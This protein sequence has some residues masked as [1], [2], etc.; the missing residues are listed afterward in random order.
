MK[1]WALGARTRKWD[2]NESEYWARFCDERNWDART[3]KKHIDQLHTSEL[4][5]DVLRS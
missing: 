4:L 3:N 1:F 5:E 2:M